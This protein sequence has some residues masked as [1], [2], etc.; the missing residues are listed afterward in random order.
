MVTRQKPILSGRRTCDASSVCHHRRLFPPSTDVSQ[1]GDQSDEP[2][3]SERRYQRA[4]CVARRAS[5]NEWTTHDAA[6]S[7]SGALARATDRPL[8]S[9]TP[10]QTDRQTDRQTNKRTNSSTVCNRDVPRPRATR[11]NIEYML[12]NDATHRFALLFCVSQP[13]NT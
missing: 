11:S 12:P 13:G 6:A 2:K 7:S 10:T 5:T 4:F 9:A 1:Y 3:C 8:A